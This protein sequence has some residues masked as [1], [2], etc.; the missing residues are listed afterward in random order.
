M[1]GFLQD[2]MENHNRMFA[3]QDRYMET[4]L[5]GLTVAQEMA[6]AAIG[7]TAVVPDAPTQGRVSTIADFRRLHPLLSR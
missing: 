1:F 4:L 3:M 5:Q 7:R 6:N 2:D